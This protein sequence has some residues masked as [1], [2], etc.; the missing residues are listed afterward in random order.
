M[1]MNLPSR[2]GTTSVVDSYDQAPTPSAPGAT[3]SDEKLNEAGLV[4]K[5]K[6]AK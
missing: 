2:S 3:A 1:M 5:K 4:E 6:D